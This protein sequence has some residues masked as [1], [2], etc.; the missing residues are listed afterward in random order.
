MVRSTTLKTK[1]I[2][3]ILAMFL[4]L[5]SILLAQTGALKG[6]VF[7]KNTNEPLIGANVIF[8]RTSLGAASDFDGNYLVRGVPVGNYSVKVSYIGY[9]AVTQDIEIV[10]NRTLD[11]DF[12]LEPQTL[13][14][15]TVVIT[16]Q[17]EGQLQAIN[18]Q[19]SSRSIKN[20][21]SSERIQQLPDESAATALSRL[22]GLSL[23]D[24][25]KVVIRGIQSKMNVVLVNGVQLPSTD[26]Q[27][28]S[29]N[30]GFISSNMLAGI[31]VV[32]AI[33][34]DMDAN[35]IGGVVNLRLMEAPKGFHYDVM[36]QG[37]YNTQDRTADN[38]K[39]WGSASTRFLD[40]K[41]GVFVQG[42]V[43]RSNAGNDAANASYERL[44]T[45]SDLPWGQ[46]TY[47]MR[48]FVYADELNIVENYG[49][50]IILD[51]VL[52]KGKLILQNTIAH[53]NNDLARY[54][55]ILD[56]YE[57][58]RTY[59]V[60]RDIH[61]KNLLIN[62]LQA[63][64]TFGSV[65]TELGLSHSF[66]DKDTD[67]RYG[68]PGE[69]FGFKSQG[70]APYADYTASRLYL[71]P[72]DVYKIEL[73]PDDWEIAE[74]YAWAGT[75][76][77]AFKQNLYNANLD[78]T[79]PVSFATGLSG[80]FKLGGKMIH[81]VRE[82]DLEREYCRI[83]E[84]QN[85]QGAADFLRSIGQDPNVTL[86]FKN[87]RDSDYKRGEYFLSGDYNMQNVVDLE[88]L[89]EFMRLSPPQWRPGR[90]ITD[91]E[92]NDFDGKETFAAGYF[93]GDFNIGTRLNIIAGLRY[94]H[95]NMN[96][97]ANFVYV[98]HSVD[99]V[100]RLYDTL[101]TVNRNDV[102]IF[103]NAHLRYK[104]TDWFDVRF[105]Y[106]NS[107]SRPDYQAI[108]PRIYFEPGGGGNAGNTKLKPSLSQNFDLFLS[109][110]NNHIGL[111]TV[112]G[113][114]KKMTDVFYQTNFYYQNLSYWDVSFPSL[115]TFN[116]L[117]LTQS[118]QKPSPSTIITSYVNNPHP[119]YVR[120]F[121]V[122]WQTNFW[123]LP[124]P[125]NYMVL[126]V[127]YTRVWSDMD[128]Q[129]IRN[130]AIPFRE[131]TRIR[132]EYVTTDTVRNARLIHQGDHI[133]NVALGI[134]YKDFS[135]RI[136]FNMQGDVITTVG[137]RPEEDQFTGNIYKWDFT[138]KQKLPLEG[139][140]ISLNGMNIFHQPVKNYQ[141][142]RTHINNPVQ[143]NL[144]S[145]LYS[146]RRF[147]LALRYSI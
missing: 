27:D 52:P 39:F 75:R 89:D 82:N 64:Y 125:F 40:D 115:E 4:V 13:S 11:F 77:E 56:L 83:T 85:N 129:Q 23:M 50:S 44:G 91:S 17:A 96:Y 61:S 33:T 59:T 127:N 41:L 133:V 94:E 9:V 84:P 109:F 60:T 146:P 66:S 16:A 29:T 143:D 123:Y 139:L 74:I 122:E 145:T 138:I 46:A 68:D 51:Y 73:R 47:G 38:Y 45:G 67:L 107:I 14:G 65:K 57:T 105:A 111:F 31:E 88:R 72:E 53:T 32:K 43:S 110:Y 19:L 98:T 97:N 69:N 8:E 113:F 120:G 25:D 76:S 137:G 70:V 63:E 86:K 140:S 117:G 15:E 124:S 90:H 30:L 78:F 1:L 142:F 92:R 147:E 6:R 114:Y 35:A 12:F 102:N 5:P 144:T 93:M 62:A 141:R 103:P 55:D 131:G 130:T 37:V 134:D 104:V 128:Y 21:V 26:V 49:G 20:V 2:I 100:G 71:T 112:G 36:G 80:E 101:N 3:P 42:N 81:S 22:P 34:P 119:A 108:L 87:F 121:E 118:N 24:G 58:K 48:S 18:Q 135:A 28:R 54:R 132:Y 79:I 7:D 116:A 126:N 10:Q 95:Y 136:S 106:T 99:G